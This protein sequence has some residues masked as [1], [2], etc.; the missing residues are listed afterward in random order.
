VVPD[1]AG[2]SLPA[3]GVTIVVAGEGDPLHV[4]NISEDFET[5]FGKRPGDPVSLWVGARSTSTLSGAELFVGPI[6][7]RAP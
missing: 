2:P 1:Q 7:F 5:F 4:R 3:S 6:A